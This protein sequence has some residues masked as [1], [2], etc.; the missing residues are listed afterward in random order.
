M[1]AG[2]I[3]MD[4][5]NIKNLS[6][7]Y[8]TASK[9]ALSDINLDIKS[10]EFVVI[11]GQ[12]GCGKSTLLRQLKR[13][14]SPHGKLEGEI[15]YNNVP[16][17]S[18]TAQ[19]SAQE[20]GFVM[21]NVDNQIV[22]DKVYH[23][24][25]FG[26]ENLGMPTHVIRL[27]VAEISSFLGIQQWF[28][29]DTDKLSGGQKQMLNLASVMVMLPKVLILD[30][31]TSQLDPIA[32][33]EFIETL[34][35]INNDL[36]MTIILSEHRLEDAFCAADRVVV[37]HQSHVVCDAPPTQVMQSLKESGMAY[38]I[39][40][41]FPSAM[42]IFSDLGENGNSPITV[43]QGREWINAHM[44]KHPALQELHP[45]QQPSP[46]K[47][48]SHPPKPLMELKEVFFTY[49]KG[50]PDILRGVNLTAFP[51]EILCILGGNGTG[52]STTLGIMA[53][54]NIPQRGIAKIDGKKLS[55]Y[56]SS[57]LYGGL[58]SLL[59][60]S[61]QALFVKDTVEADLLECTQNQADLERV[62]GL[63]GMENLRTAHPFD[64]SGG[65]A[66]KAAFA[67]ILLKNPKIILLDEPTKGLDAVFKQQLANILRNL[68]N[69]GAAIIIATHDI[70]FSAQ[71]ADK[72]AMFFD[73]SVISAARPTD[74][75]S[76]NSYYTT[77][78]NRM[79]RHI[80]A[81][82]ITCEEV[83]AL[84]KINFQTHQT[85]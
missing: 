27:R 34:K 67:K 24:L 16:L 68:A 84:C 57:Q 45:S 43:K 58:V 75:F 54:L 55:S 66:Q 2:E 83:S 30:E 42:R 33:T 38:P 8:P 29:K 31:P 14:L 72:C 12:S 5:F 35:K 18:L 64:L 3:I 62:I 22:T 44:P 15:L 10:G 51:G 21:Q 65:E 36:N 39:Q 70:E 52:K 25:A 59:P 74:F 49:Q 4:L 13:E 53:G 19:A 23:E 79:I 78:A 37:M 80:C 7:T 50:T 41:G 6:F 20:I 1:E 26:L 28:R 32:A 48:H 40:K 73:G 56:K 77:T 9:K 60:Q 11:C 76:G 71:F 63:M 81:H 82:A 61:P 85:S 17:S 69:H 47:S 46:Q